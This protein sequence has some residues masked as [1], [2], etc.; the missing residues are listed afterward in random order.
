MLRVTASAWQAAARAV[1]QFPLSSSPS[2]FS[3]SEIDIRQVPAVSLCKFYLVA[4]Y[5]YYTSILSALPK[6]THTQSL[7]TLQSTINLPA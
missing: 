7:D 2:K 4:T 5:Q 3:S 1:M 6:S